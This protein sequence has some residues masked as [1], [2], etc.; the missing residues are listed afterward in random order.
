MENKKSKLEEKFNS[1][2]VKNIHF[3]VSCESRKKINIKE[4]LG[5][6]DITLDDIKKLKD[7]P[8]IANETY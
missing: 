6:V 1:L 2:G 8:E 7:N 3:D 5:E 4:V